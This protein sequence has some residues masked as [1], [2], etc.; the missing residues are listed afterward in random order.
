M[1]PAP[2]DWHAKKYSLLKLELQTEQS[3]KNGKEAGQSPTTTYLLPAL[4]TVKQGVPGAKDRDT[5]MLQQG[6]CSQPEKIK[7]KLLPLTTL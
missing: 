2:I 3:N 4:R 1:R 6:Y 5:R 7:N